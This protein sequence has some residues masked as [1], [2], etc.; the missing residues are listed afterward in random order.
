MD[1][2]LGVRIKEGRNA[3]GLTQDELAKKLNV[4]GKSVISNYEKGYS[5]PDLDTLAKMAKIFGCSVDY[6]LGRTDE[7]RSPERISE[8]ATPY[9]L[10]P[11]GVMYFRKLKNLSPE[12]RK[13]FIEAFNAHTK[14]IEEF[15]KNQ[16]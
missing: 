8:S 7:P 15:E 9:D 13:K 4:S 16:K 14:L 1:N 10:P 5:K 12:T 3:L 6:L 2:I 11:E